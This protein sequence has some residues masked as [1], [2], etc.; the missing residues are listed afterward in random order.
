MGRFSKLVVASGAL[1]LFIFTGPRADMSTTA[2]LERPAIPASATDLDAWLTRSEQAY[3]DV[4]PGAEKTVV[5]AG[6]PGERTDL[7]VVYLHGWSASRQETRPFADRVADRL[8]ANLYYTRLT[9][10]GRAG[11]SMGGITL[12]HLA[13]DARETLEIGRL[14]GDRTI[15][16]GT[17]T[18]ATLGLWL[19]AVLGDHAVQPESMVLISPNFAPNDG[20][21]GIMLWP[22]GRHLLRLVQGD[23]MSWTP[24]NERHERFWTTSY[25][26][27]SLIPMMSLVRLTRRADLESIEMPVIVFYS[28]DDG[29]IDARLIPGQMA[30]L[31]GRVELVN[32]PDP[33]DRNH[34][35]L[36]GD[37]LSPGT[38]DRLVDDAVRFLEREMGLR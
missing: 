26:S 25:P 2:H 18:G 33:E 22:W 24:E 23:T 36:A 29:V 30:R 34:H 17:S 19:A 3:G 27:E 32:V 11:E 35:V 1:A 20:R 6:E 14:L 21:A 38:T 28:E 31:S 10:H 16:V 5:W 37:I 4:V 7:A 13:A 8:G 15:L 12:D 9:G